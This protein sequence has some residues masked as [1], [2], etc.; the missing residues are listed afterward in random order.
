L[1]G[2]FGATRLYDC[3][4]VLL[5]LYVDLSKTFFDLSKS[6][7]KNLGTQ[8]GEVADG[9][10][11]TGAVGTQEILISKTT[12]T[13]FSILN[14]VDDV[15]VGY[16]KVDGNDITIKMDMTGSESANLDKIEILL[17]YTDE[18][19]WSVTTTLLDMACSADDVRAPRRILLKMSKAN[20]LWQGKAMLYNPIWG[21]GIVNGHSGDPTCDTEEGDE[22]SMAMYTDFVG[23]D[24]AAKAKVFLMNK[25]IDSIEGIEDNPL[26]N[27]CAN[28]MG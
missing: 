17:S 15:S 16:V 11:T 22:I 4:P 5:R 3:Q 1:R 20:S 25:T 8:I 27:V 6:I 18:S 10:T 13:D 9:S 26:S 12:S 28:Y 7:V 19:N 2:L 23:N 14:K 24:T 21:Q